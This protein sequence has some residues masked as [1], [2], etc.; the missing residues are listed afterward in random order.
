M[1]ESICVE[2][3][4]SFPGS[5]FVA[6][7]REIGFHLLW[8]CSAAQVF[9]ALS[10]SAYLGIQSPVEHFAMRSLFLSAT[11]TVL[12]Q[13]LSRRFP[14]AFASTCITMTFFFPSQHWEGFLWTANEITLDPVSVGLGLAQDT[15]H[16]VLVSFLLWVLCLMALCHS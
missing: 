11:G 8:I 12:T 6:G 4:Y 15:M 5:F 2:V 9:A 10:C 16:F 1:T 14:D 3:G 7:G 13:R